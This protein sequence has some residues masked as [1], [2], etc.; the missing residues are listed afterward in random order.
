[1]FNFTVGPTPNIVKLGVDPLKMRIFILTV[2]IVIRWTPQQSS[3]PLI[4]VWV[5]PEVFFFLERRK[6]VG[7]AGRSLDLEF[8][9]H[10]LHPW[11]GL[12]GLSSLVTLAASKWNTQM[13]TNEGFWL[14]N[15]SDFRAFSGY[16]SLYLGELHWW[17]TCMPCV[18]WLCVCSSYS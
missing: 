4:V 7:V 9:Q 17:Y 15:Q 6:G 1:M 12:L 14:S 8:P 10:P 11:L 5:N 18:K 2:Q 3:M 13:T 16:R